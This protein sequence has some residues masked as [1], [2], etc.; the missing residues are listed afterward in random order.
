MN[1]NEIAI[2]E[3]SPITFQLSENQC[4]QL[5]ERVRFSM[6]TWL[7][8]AAREHKSWM[9]Y[10]GLFVGIGVGCV[11][12]AFM[13][14]EVAEVLIKGLTHL[15]GSLARREN[16]QFKKGIEFICLGA[17]AFALAAPVRF[18]FIIVELF[19]NTYGMAA[20]AENFT[21][22]RKMSH[23]PHRL[24]VAMNKANGAKR[25]YKEAILIY[26][27][28]RSSLSEALL[29]GM[30]LLGHGI[31]KSDEGIKKFFQG[32]KPI[33][34]SS[35]VK[36]VNPLLG[37]GMKG[38]EHAS[39]GTLKS[40]FDKILPGLLKGTYHYHAAEAEAALSWI[41][42]EWAAG[43]GKD[44]VTFK[45]I[46]DLIACLEKCAQEGDDEMKEWV[47]QR[48]QDGI[49]IGDKRLDQ[50]LKN[51]TISDELQNLKKL[52][53]QF[54]TSSLHPVPLLGE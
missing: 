18:A 20:N 3:Q 14:M 23:H 17:I 4:P 10:S 31:E 41:C 21:F 30:Q 34:F 54:A 28:D 25:N 47:E 19:T 35:S 32:T 48:F 38:I 52:Q 2:S 24:D 7:N 8:D 29:V 36:S 22:K 51:I 46:D 39:D 37:L 12:V 27:T 53:A 43:T 5:Q 50:L 40:L 1:F 33:Q 16:C 6:Y 9:P 45:M 49:W 42:K 15:F 11:T 44:Q 26:E 13:V